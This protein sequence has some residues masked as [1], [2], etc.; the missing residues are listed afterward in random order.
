MFRKCGEFRVCRY[1]LRSVRLEKFRT[2][3]RSSLEIY[4]HILLSTFTQSHPAVPSKYFE[5]KIYYP[6]PP[7]QIHQYIADQLPT[8][9]LS[10]N[11]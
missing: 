10:V 9:L 2:V 5:H 6:L 11:L 8:I 3:L 1:D 7:K 4:R